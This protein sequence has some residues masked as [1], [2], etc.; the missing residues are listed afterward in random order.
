MKQKNNCP[1]RH[2]VGRQLKQIRESIRITQLD[3]ATEMDVC[4][5]TIHRLEQGLPIIHRNVLLK[6]YFKALKDIL[7]DRLANV[8]FLESML[9]H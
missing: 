3:I 8:H 9:N 2:Q 6:A 5:K 7:S 4:T 1:H